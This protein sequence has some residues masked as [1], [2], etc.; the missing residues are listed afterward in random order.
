M[1]SRSR[2]S[3]TPGQVD[4]TR[5][6]HGVE[7]LLQ[8]AAVGVGE[9]GDQRRDRTASYD[10]RQ[11]ARGSACRHRAS[12]EVHRMRSSVSGRVVYPSV[13]KPRNSE[14]VELS[15]TRS[16]SPDRTLVPSAS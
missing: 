10:A 5:R 11:S 4:T 1:G 13:A 9:G 16:R 2:T 12:T 3:S 15:R 6:A 14:P 7:G 8:G